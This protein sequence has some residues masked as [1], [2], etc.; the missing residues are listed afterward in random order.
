MVFKSL[1]VATPRGL[2]C[3]TART[4]ARSTRSRQNNI[5]SQSDRLLYFRGERQSLPSELHKKYPISVSS[6][7]VTK[8]RLVTTLLPP[9]PRRRLVGSNY[10]AL[11]EMMINR[12]DNRSKWRSKGQD[13]CKHV[14]GQKK[15]SWTSIQNQTLCP[16]Q[17]CLGPTAD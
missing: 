4:Q 7:D 3:S 11:R 9:Q 12:K 8:G 2:L 10:K 17:E 16:R 13:P 14:E 6:C 15:K 5:Y 1:T